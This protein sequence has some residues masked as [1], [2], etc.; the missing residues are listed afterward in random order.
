MFG[1]LNVTGVQ[2]GVSNDLNGQLLCG[3]RRAFWYWLMFS[4]A[5]IRSIIPRNL[6]SFQPWHGALSYSPYLGLEHLL[7]SRA[8]DDKFVL[9]VAFTFDYK[10]MFLNFMCN[11]DRLEIKEHLVLAAFD[12][13]VFAWGTQHNLPIFL[14]RNMVD[15]NQTENRGARWN[16]TELEGG[17]FDSPGFKSATKAKTVAT[18]N[19]L[20]A[21][22]SVVWSDLDIV[23]FENPFQALS[24]CMSDRNSICI[25]SDMPLHSLDPSKNLNSGMYVAPSSPLVKAAFRDIVQHQ[26]RSTE[27]QQKSFNKVLCERPSMRLRDACI[28]RPSAK[29]QEI[30]LES[31]ASVTAH[32]LPVKTLDRIQ[33]ANGAP[34][35]GA[36][37]KDVFQLGTENFSNATSSKVVM[38]HNNYIVGIDKKK[39]RQVSAGWWFIDGNG[40]CQK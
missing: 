25:Q 28:Y 11:L 16:T 9:L 36:G 18:L 2:V 10:E 31:D 29:E 7:Q 14:V 6:V 35:Q 39:E 13:K 24:S 1:Q 37:E 17:K 4:A 40:K 19:V 3:K 22:Y 32:I 23:W 33:Y 5:L 26:A 34:V 30:L 15:R 21:G 38:A 12:E 27:S 8:N 20:E